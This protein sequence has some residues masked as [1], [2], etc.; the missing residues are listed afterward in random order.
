MIAINTLGKPLPEGSVSQP[1]TTTQG[2][3]KQNKPKKS[4]NVGDLAV[5]MK[6]DPSTATILRQV[7]ERKLAAVEEEDYV[8]AK[9]YK[10]VE[11]YLKQIGGE[12]SSLIQ[13][14]V[15]SLSR[16]NFWILLWFHCFFQRAEPGCRGGRL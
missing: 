7:H 10:T 8:L 2:R 11:D 14:K 13:A 4:S 9:Q 6:L 16:I 5:D 12:L 3:S 15:S 1:S